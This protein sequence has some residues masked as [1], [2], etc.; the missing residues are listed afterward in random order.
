MSFPSMVCFPGGGG[1]GNKSRV[2][3]GMKNDWIAIANH[4]TGGCIYVELRFDSIAR[5][6]ES[7]LVKT[8]SA[9]QIDW[10]TRDSS[11]QGNTNK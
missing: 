10:T 3:Q 6:P 5:G 1:L 2:V 9:D 4:F 8:H 11:S 7:T